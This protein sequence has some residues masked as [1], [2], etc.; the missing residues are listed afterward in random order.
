MSGSRPLDVVKCL[1]TDLCV[2]MLTSE[3]SHGHAVDAT[4]LPSNA[5]IW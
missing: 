2:E 1:Y 3:G 4:S 5:R